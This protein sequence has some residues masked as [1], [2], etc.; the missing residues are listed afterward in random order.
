LSSLLGRNREFNEI[1]TLQALIHSAWS[2]SNERSRN[3]IFS[4][5][6]VTAASTAENENVVIS[7][8]HVE[9]KQQQKPLGWKGK[10]GRG[11]E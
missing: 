11:E 3:Q 10:R 6:T 1:L 2:S 4:R 7:S 8:E 9:V 5:L